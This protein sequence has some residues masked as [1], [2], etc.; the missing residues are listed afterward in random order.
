[1]TVT[2][3]GLVTVGAL[4]GSGGYGTFINDGLSRS[5]STP[6]IVGGGL[7]IAM[8]IVFDVL[9]VLLQRVLTPWARGGG[10]P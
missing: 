10:H 5:F 6:I 1:A 9:F 8:A 4:V 2:I 3:I 7:S